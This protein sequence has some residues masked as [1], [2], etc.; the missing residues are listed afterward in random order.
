MLTGTTRTVMNREIRTIVAIMSVKSIVSRKTGLRKRYEAM[1]SPVPT[2]YLKILR[3]T[4][5]LK[6]LYV[7]GSSL[8]SVTSIMSG[9]AK[10]DRERLLSFDSPGFIMDRSILW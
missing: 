8:T 4:S 7:S 10:R 2:V 9:T 5:L 1:I 6:P 3:K